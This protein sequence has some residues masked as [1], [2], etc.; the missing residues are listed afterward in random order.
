MIS[1]FIVFVNILSDYLFDYLD[2]PNY[3]QFENCLYTLI[4]A[5]GFKILSSIYQYS[6]YSVGED[7]KVLTTNLLPI[8]MFTIL[9][10]IFGATSLQ[11]ISVLLLISYI[12]QFVVRGFIYISV[13]GKY[14]V[15]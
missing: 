5:L 11:H 10:L 8:L 2:K 15:S 13:K 7:L 12:T 4:V 6:F 14:C 9:I 1:S 3:K